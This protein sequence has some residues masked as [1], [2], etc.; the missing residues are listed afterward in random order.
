M[1]MKNTIFT[2]MFWN[3][4]ETYASAFTMHVKIFSRQCTYIERLSIYDLL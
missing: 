4:N 3:P 2:Q 1:V